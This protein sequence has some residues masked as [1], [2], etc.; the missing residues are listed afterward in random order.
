[1]AIF[2]NVNPVTGQSQIGDPL[3]RMLIAQSQSQQ[4][5]RHPLELAGRLAQFGVGAWIENDER[6]TSE[7]ELADALK[8]LPGLGTPAAPTT[9]APSTP[10]PVTSAAPRAVPSRDIAAS[11]IPGKPS[12]PAIPRAMPTIEAAKAAISRNESGGRYDA[13]GPATNKAGN[14]AYGKYQVMDFNIGPWTQEV[15]GKPMTPQEFLAN[16][17]AQER[18]FEAKFG[19]LMKQHGFAGASRA[20]FTGS[21]TGTGKDILGTTADRYVASAERGL[22]ET[23]VAEAPASTATDGPQIPPAIASRIQVLLQSRNPAVKQLGMQLYTTYAKPEKGTDDMREYAAAQQQGYK[24]TLLD[25]L[26]EKKAPLVQI[27]QRGETE[28]AKAV[29]KQQ[30]KR[31]DD[32][33]QAGHDAKSMIANIQSLR[34]ISSRITTG[35]TTELKAALGPYAEMFGAKIDGLDDIQAFQAIVSRLAPQMRPPG[36]GATSDFEMRKFLESLPSLGRTPGGN[37][38]ISRTLDAIS[39]HRIAAGEIASRA[40]SGE[41]SVKEAEKQLRA[42]PDPLT[43]WKQSRGT[44]VAPP[45]SERPPPPPGYR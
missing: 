23:R 39:E 24:G 40:M 41:I 17:E 9:P 29:G 30:A 28:F 3:A 21:P 43:L 22:P 7:K 31:F 45:P 36:T 44:T 12:A 6:R 4:P 18:V 42:L 14:R 11:H 35:K 34:E 16:P 25:F 37:E 19:Q 26:K 13:L 33:V 1:M 2:G 15:L 27:D 38:L 10:S 5:M 32:I 20:W 8:N